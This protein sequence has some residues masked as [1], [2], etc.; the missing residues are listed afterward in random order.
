M[1]VDRVT[2][3]L[4]AARAAR[5]EAARLNAAILIKE[6]SASEQLAL[7]QCS[8]EQSAMDR[9]QRALAARRDENA[10][11]VRLLH[12]P[13]GMRVRIS[14]TPTQQVRSALS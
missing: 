5:A 3:R 13:G 6:G 4:H 2:E 12:T 8:P 1:Q 7:R 10:S 11:S 9:L 14:M